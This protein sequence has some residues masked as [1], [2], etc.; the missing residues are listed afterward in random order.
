ML[1]HLSSNS[2]RL[3]L[4]KN[5]LQIW[6]ED[7][8]RTGQRSENQLFLYDSGITGKTRSLNLTVANPS[9]KAKQLKRKR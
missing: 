3:R 5:L 7:K 9:S 8:D 2:D 1:V 6:L 4:Y